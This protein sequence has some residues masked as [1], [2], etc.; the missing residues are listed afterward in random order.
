[1]SPA[2]AKTTSDERRIVLVIAAVQFINVLDF[3]MVMPLGPDFA[4]ALGF[5]P[6]HIGYVGGSYTLAAAVAGLAG[7][8]FL[9]RFDRRTALAVTLAGLV[10]ATAL[11]GLAV[12]LPTLLAT[13]VLAGLFGGPAVALGIA[14]VADCVAPERRGRAMGV[15]M[16]T[17]SLAAVLGLPVGLE[18]ARLGG[19]RLPFFAVA[20]LA[21]VVVAAAMAVLPPQRGHLTEGPGPAVLARLGSLLS[22]RAVWLAY[23]TA[24]LLQMQAFVVIPNISAYVQHNLGYPR[25]GLGLLYMVGGALTF[26]GMRAAGRT[27]DRYGSA[28]VTLVN[29]LLMT[30]V[31]WAGFLDYRAWMPILVIFPLF[32]LS[33]GARM[34]ANSAVYSRVPHPQERAGFMALV[35][36]VTHV[37]AAAGSFLSAQILE[38]LPDGRLD[39]VAAMAWVAIALG[40]A[41]PPL[42]YG[43]ERVLRPAPLPQPA[44]KPHAAD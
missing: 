17:F 39:N 15:V 41:V 36:A 25:D 33:N 14:L 44:P 11:G 37:A 5:A 26:F 22:R 32:M 7:S 2:A 18:L 1:M 42:M 9:D 30:G 43:L 12:D 20:G 35:S 38:T 6:S 10:V 16:G 3:M 19:W 8:A 27:V 21:A 4:A 29:T 28:P 34:V 31:L 40:L 24:G 13:R 23:A